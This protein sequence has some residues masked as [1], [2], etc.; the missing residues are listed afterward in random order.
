MKKTTAFSLLIILLVFFL[1]GAAALIYQ[2]AWQR[3]L[4]VYY[5]VGFYS[6]TLIV[7]IYMFGMG[8]G[9]YVGGKL[10]E[11]VKEK[12]KLYLGIEILIG[13]F[14]VASPYILDFIGQK[15]AGVNYFFTA[16]LLFLFL[17][18]PTLLMGATLPLLVKIYNRIRKDF[19]RSVSRLYFVNT[20]GAASGALFAT[21]FIISFF[22]LDTAVYCASAL[23]LFIGMIVYFSGKKFQ[24][25]F[26]SSEQ[27]NANL[28]DG[29]KNFI[30][31]HLT[32][33]IVFITGFA[34]IGYELVWFRIISILTK[35][36]AYAFSTVLFVYLL[37][38]AIGSY[39]VNNITKKF[40]FHKK[41][42][43]YFMLQFLLGLF[44]IVSFYLFYQLNTFPNY[45]SAITDESFNNDTHPLFNSSHGIREF[46]INYDIFFYPLLFVLIPTI[47]MGASFP[48]INEITKRKIN[49]EG[50]TVGN[51]Y[52]FNVLG[53]VMGG[54]LT[55]FVLLPLIKTSGTLAVFSS[56]NTLFLLGTIRRKQNK[57]PAIILAAILIIFNF[58]AFPDNYSF[59]SSIHSNYPHKFKSNNHKTALEEG[60]QS[61][62]VTYYNDTS[63]YRNFINGSSHGFRPG[64]TYYYECLESIRYAKKAENILIIGFGAGSITEA[65][66]KFPSTKK[67]TLVEIN[68]TLL[69]NFAKIPEI[70]N[71]LFHPK[72]ITVIEDG[73]RF[74]NS[75][76]EKFDIILL[77]PLRSQVAY[78]NNINSKE[79]FGIVK[80]HLSSD[81]IVMVGGQYD[82][83]KTKTLHLALPEIRC[84]KFFLLGALKPFSVNEEAASRYLTTFN[85]WQV[86]NILEQNS[87][88]GDYFSMSIQFC[89][90]PC[91]TDWKPVNEYYLGKEYKIQKCIHEGKGQK[92]NN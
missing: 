81:G 32:Y 46:V 39:F 71:I 14:G 74:L 26:S 91:N 47:I 29:S 75:V 61:V 44:V 88:I 72:L 87:Y 34:A 15:T 11:K 68:K 18:L 17:S 55:G 73:R 66:L 45:F 41:K 57:I 40:S 31:I 53:N 70:K 84:Y 1:S 13:L 59:Y 79:F 2:V 64:Y 36:S 9:G 48:L 4:T 60:R 50:N 62:I 16:V 25:E 12:I 30:P 89:N 6:V 27:E 5:G 85:N 90:Y 19:F 49:A 38:L 82:P 24:T 69:D 58:L 67:V 3:L 37:G 54:M 63:V 56:V 86:K 33:L 52:F 92:E 80:T 20:L 42:N 77:D 35:D 51:I 10:S 83:V 22:G 7:S 43:F 65:F 23:N 28:P 8:I 78:S 76:N 21:F